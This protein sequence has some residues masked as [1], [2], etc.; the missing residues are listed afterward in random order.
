MSQIQRMNRI[1]CNAQ[2][3]IV[4]AAG[5]DSHYGLPGVGHRSRKPQEKVSLGG[6]TLVQQC[7]S[8]VAVAKS[9][10]SSRAWTGQEG[11]L[12]TRCLVFTDEE[13]IFRCR[14]MFCQESRYWEGQCSPASGPSN[15]YDED[16]G[17]VDAIPKAKEIQTN[18]P[19]IK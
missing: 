1:Y 9:K 14:A 12:S 8:G 3:C 2:T 7:A 18:P 16:D 13:V 4:A 17:L 15:V 19:K 11:C 6:L 5:D 10:W